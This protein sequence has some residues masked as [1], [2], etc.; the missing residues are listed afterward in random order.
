MSRNIKIGLLMIVILLIAALSVAATRGW[1]GPLFQTGMDMPTSTTQ[2]QST[3]SPATPIGQGTPTPSGND[4]QQSLPSP[5]MTSIFTGFTPYPNAMATYGI[6][7]GSGGMIGGGMMGYASVMTGTMGTYGMGM[8]GMDMSACP[9]MSGVEHGERRHGSGF[10][11]VRDGYGQEF[12][13]GRDG[14]GRGFVD[15]W[16]GY[17]CA[18]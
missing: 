14:Y 16:H 7:M 6:P 10:V 9:M 1:N 11:D 8:S 13:D 15:G 5:T 12:V 3:Q 2:P 17:E 4:A 18:G